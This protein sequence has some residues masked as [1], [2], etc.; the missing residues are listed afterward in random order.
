MTEKFLV[1]YASRTGT[2]AGVADAIGKMLIEKGD[3]HNCDEI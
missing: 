1:T 2:A 3:H